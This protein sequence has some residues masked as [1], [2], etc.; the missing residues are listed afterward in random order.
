[1][2]GN[3]PGR[4]DNQRTTVEVGAV[5]GQRFEILRLLG[6][7]GMGNVYLARDTELEEL[8]A[9]KLLHANA[10]EGPDALDLLKMFRREVRLARRITHV[11]VAR[12]YDIG[13]HGTRKFMTMELIEGQSLH[14]ELERNGPFPV[15]RLEA[16]LVSMARGLAAAHDAGV[17]HRDLKPDNVL[18]ESSSGRIVVTDFG[19]A[20]PLGGNKTTVNSRGTLV[21]MAPEQLDTSAALDH[22][23]DIYALGVTLFELATGRL[24]FDGASPIAIAAARLAHEA[25]DPRIFRQD[26]PAPFADLVLRCLQRAPAERFASAAEVL[27]AMGHGSDTMAVS[28]PR[29]VPRAHVVA[30]LPFEGPDPFARL[31]TEGVSDA[32][33]GTPHLRCTSADVVRRAR[34]R[35]EEPITLGVE[36]GADAVATGRVD[37]RGDQLKVTLRGFG[38]VEQTLFFSRTITCTAERLEGVLASLATPFAGALGSAIQVA[39]A[40]TN[41][42]GTPVLDAKSVAE[43]AFLELPKSTLSGLEEAAKRS[44]SDP[45]V[46]VPLGLALLRSYF[47]EGETAR[48]ASATKAI[49]AAA[50]VAPKHPEVLHARALLSLHRGNV[51]D[52]VR[53]LG[54]AVDSSD[55]ALSHE[56]LGGLFVEL[57]RSDLAV[58]HFQIALG[59]NR[60]S[61]ASLVE[62]VRLD[63]YERRWGRARDA[64]RAL[65]RRLPPTTHRALGEVEL[66]VALWS[67]DLSTIRGAAQI[68][69][70]SPFLPA[71]A[72]IALREGDLA[73]ALRVTTAAQVV[74]RSPRRAALVGQMEAEL[75]MIASNPTAA[76][77]AIDRAIRAGLF[78]VAWLEQCPILDA[79]RAHDDYPRRLA[80]VRQRANEALLG[81]TRP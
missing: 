68:V 75:A 65:R 67:G 78:D 56:T 47:L 17:I 59:E 50:T 16:C 12:V 76:F 44:P 18:V 49:D 70:Q 35:Q 60:D 58:R 69:E 66:R 7:G 20:R 26:L 33:V 45:S 21:Y 31:A 73:E 81:V 23:V 8:V 19:V 48:L 77:L 71:A 34:E 79:A 25:L 38:V 22:R 54:E 32:L 42:A 55:S 28:A 29:K 40:S 43:T 6:S 53:L 57:G 24:P 3:V 46:L 51:R 4:S 72:V 52:C 63:V 5:V 9:L 14:D 10:R 27:Q 30:V 61:L 15:H 11:N 74:T 80:V 39:A 64:L 62:L 13:T 36:V 2:G 41:A 37:V 1:M